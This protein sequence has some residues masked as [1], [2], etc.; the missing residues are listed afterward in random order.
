MNRA[1]DSLWC[2]GGG[3]LDDEVDTIL[4]LANLS[5]QVQPVTLDL[6]SYEG[7][8]PQEMIGGAE[9]PTI[10]TAPYFLSLGPYASYWF[11]L[12]A[13]EPVMLWT[14]GVP[15]AVEALATSLPVLVLSG[16]W[17]T[18]FAQGPRRRL[19]TD[20]L[21]A[22]LSQ[23]RW[24]SGKARTIARLRLVDYCLIQA[25]RSP[26]CVVRRGRVSCT[27]RWGLTLPPS[28]CSR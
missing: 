12:H 1:D 18:L 14:E 22:Y 25:L 2:L 6:T 21:P 28:P 26:A 9:F 23:Q 17:E 8:I 5:N 7:L 3:R 10:S 16:R 13:P 24:F 20:V 11:V 4:V 15:S 27:M 19:E